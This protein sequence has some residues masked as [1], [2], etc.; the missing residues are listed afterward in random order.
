[1]KISPNAS[2]AGMRFFAFLTAS[3][4]LAIATLVSASS[5]HQVEQLDSLVIPRTSH[6]ATALSDGRILIT[7]GHDSAG[8]LV[9]VSEIFDPETQTST[10]SAML[11]TARADHTATRL[12]DG[13][14]LVTGGTGDSGPLSSAEIFDPANAD[15]GFQVLPSTMTAARAGH[16]ATLLSN[17]T[18]LIA[19]GEGTGTAEIFDPTTELF[20]P[21]LWNLNVPRSGHTATLFTDDSVLLAGGNTNS[22]ELFTPSDQKFTLEAAAMSGARTGHWALELSNTRLLFF[23]GDAGNTIDEYNPATG[24]ITPKGS[25]DVGATSTTLLVNGKVLVLGSDVAGLY[26]ANTVPPTP[27]FVAFD[28]TS[29]PGSS[30]LPRNG[31]SATELPGDKKILISGGADTNNL[32][33]GMALFNPARIWTDR[34]DYY[35]DEPV[36]LSGSG[37]IANEAVYLYAV[38]N[39]TQRWEYGTTVTADASG[40]FVVDPY[41]IVELR[42]LGLQF[43]ATAVGAQSAMQADVYFTDNVTGTLYENSGRTIK[44]DAFVWGATVYLGATFNG[45]S[46]NR[47]YKVEWVNPSNT[48]VQTAQFEPNTLA[49]SFLVPSS[50][51]SGIWQVKLYEANAIGPCNGAPF[52]STP[53]QTLTFDVARAV[54]IGALAD[55]YVDL[56][57]PNTVQNAAGTTLIVAKKSGTDEQR[58]FLRFDLSG[59]SGTINSAKLRLGISAEGGSA[60]NRN[61]DVYRVTATWTDTSI[62]WNN[63]PAVAGSAT[64]SQTVTAA[65]SLMRWTVTSD[66][67]GFVAGTFTN[68]GWRVSDPGLAQSNSDATYGSTQANTSTDK[69]QGPVLLV[70]YTSPTPTPT[71]TPTATPTPTPTAT[72][73]VTPTPTP[74]PTPTIAPTT[75][76]VAAASGTYG[77]TTSFSATLT[78]GASGVSGKIISFTR[79]GTSVGSATTNGSGVATLTGVSLCGVNAGTHA[80]GVGASVA[81]DGSYA[82]SNGTAS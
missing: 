74:T 28:E 31:Q 12:A 21:T 17:G 10:A 32:F 65:P 44:R 62:N 70:D 7:G 81:G 52:P 80:S 14:V 29:V 25:L 51:P 39:E 1:M 69:T 68:F 57:N 36:I 9:A 48:V 63:Q 23:E 33:M 46:G 45:Q 47:C 15:A 54:V 55:N 41:F 67:A 66:V 5:S 59:I 11:S 77:G 16:T 37:W 3:A 60:L 40:A 75:L 43:H 8:N 56:K 6:V 20:S 13:R 24:T 58:T 35:P 26:D 4:T 64:N 72:P 61:H 42:H 19:G 2:N 49:D 76:T 27:P 38:D 78:S 30:I 53:T 79:N 22:V 73:T 18:V 34:D 71:P 82:T 50:G